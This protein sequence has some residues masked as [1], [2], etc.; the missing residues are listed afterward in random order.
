MLDDLLL[1]K[2]YLKDLLDYMYK[3]HCIT[4]NV[5]CELAISV[6]DVFWGTKSKS[7]L[8]F[9]PSCHDFELSVLSLFKN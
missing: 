3:L 1:V 9:A 7:E 2:W 5:S 6:L 8:V 4:K